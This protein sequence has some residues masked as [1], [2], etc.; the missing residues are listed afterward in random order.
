MRG[1]EDSF[2]AAPDQ[3]AVERRERDVRKGKGALVLTVVGG[4]V[5]MA[6][7]YQVLTE[8]TPGAL[9]ATMAGL[10][11]AFGGGALTRH[12]TRQMR[13][14]VHRPNAGLVGAAK[15]TGLLPVRCA[16]WWSPAA[17][18]SSST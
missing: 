18:G 6:A 7:G 2:V 16:L 9:V 14:R 3:A 17:A 10:L 15:L 13:F 5:A 1:I 4:F 12:L 11:A 8:F